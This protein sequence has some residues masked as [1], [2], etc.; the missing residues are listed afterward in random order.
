MIDTQT[1]I[2]C[3]PLMRP[4]PALR[5]P[6]GVVHAVVWLEL[7]LED[8][9]HEL[10]GGRMVRVGQALCIEQNEGQPPVLPQQVTA[11][12]MDGLRLVPRALNGSAKGQRPCLP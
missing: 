6:F 7:P 4:P 10:D 5:T 3:R 2:P 8:L 9:R 12:V 1:P 11:G